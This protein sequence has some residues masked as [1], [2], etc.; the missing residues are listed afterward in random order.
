M[1]SFLSSI[2]LPNGVRFRK[3]HDF[4]ALMRQDIPNETKKDVIFDILYYTT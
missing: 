3:I 1:I 2:I 4:A